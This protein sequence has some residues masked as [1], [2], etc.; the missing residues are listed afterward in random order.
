MPSS[1]GLSPGVSGAF[2]AV[3]LACVTQGC[4]LV[5]DLG[6]SQYEPL[7]ATDAGDGGG[8]GGSGAVFDLGGIATACTDAG[9][10]VASL[11]CKASADCG[12]DSLCCFGPALNGDACSLQSECSVATG[13]CAPLV[14]LCAGPSECIGGLPCVEQSC[15]VGGFSL[16]IKN[17]GAIP[18]C[19]PLGGDA[20]VPTIEEDATAADALAR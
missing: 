13:S 1:T 2:A 5:M 3:T 18:G 8:D 9:V 19:I 11:G 12:A 15:A 6:T 14:Q 4:S 10:R 17:C 16:L 7:P 20:S